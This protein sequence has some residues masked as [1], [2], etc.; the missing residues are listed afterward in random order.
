MENEFFFYID[1]VGGC[2]LKCPACAIGNSHSIP[3]AKGLMKPALLDRIMRKAVGECKVT[4]VG[5]YNWTEPLLHPRLSELVHIVRS[6]GI[7]CSISTNLSVSKSFDDLLESNPEMI[8]VSTSGFTQDVYERTH[9]GGDIELVK[10][11]MQK[12]VEAKA[13]YGSTTALTVIFIRYKSNQQ[14][15]AMMRDYAESLGFG[16]LAYSARM[17]PLEKVLAYVGNDPTMP[18]LTPNDFELI[19]LLT[20]PLD[21]AMKIAQQNRE[22]SCTLLTKQFVINVSGNVE[23]CCGVFDSGKYTISNFLDM[24][25]S[26]I[27]TLRSSHPMC[28]KCTA[29]GGHVYY[30]PTD[31]KDL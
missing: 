11:N 23:L 3:R 30:G 9:K 28:S 17:L 12:L 1:V 6:H 25:M 15:E 8:Y 7:P 24:P 2:N 20:T 19:N 13:K 27:Q 21:E 31:V 4:S 14:D 18:Q 26:Q 5:L 16:F 29:H 10:K 22:Q